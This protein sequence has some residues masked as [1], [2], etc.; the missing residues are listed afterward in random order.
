MRDILRKGHDPMEITI[1][2]GIG[3]PLKVAPD[4]PT[5]SVLRHA[6]ALFG[7]AGAHSLALFTESG[8]ELA[9]DETL[10]HNGVM[11]NEKLILRA[12][13]PKES[14]DVIIIYN[15]I[16]KQLRVHLEEFIKSI[17]QKAIVLFSP[18]PN[19]HLLSLFTESGNE[20]PDDKTVK[21]VDLRPDEKLLLRPSAVK[22]G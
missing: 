17:L 4:E 10:E 7:L 14:F 19:P 8:R 21:Q 22:G 18:L 12:G 6:E 3:K 1:C 9:D 2:D 16:K 15:G 11:A 13:R 20:L 5:K